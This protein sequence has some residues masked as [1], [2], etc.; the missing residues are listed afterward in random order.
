MEKQMEEI[1]DEKTTHL[2][3]LET[4]EIL[5]VHEMIEMNLQL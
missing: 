4:L 2:V 3:L 1:L 5:E